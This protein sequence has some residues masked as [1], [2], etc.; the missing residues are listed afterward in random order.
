MP[1]AAQVLQDP[2]VGRYTKE[3]LFYTY[4]T[5]IPSQQENS[6]DC[7]KGM[8]NAGY[9][10]AQYNQES[11]KVVKI[12]RGSTDPQKSLCFKLPMAKDI[13]LVD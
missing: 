2:F 3:S 8:L 4:Y 11:W 10:P 1:T 13:V 12:F 9:S 7:V 6:Y 5:C